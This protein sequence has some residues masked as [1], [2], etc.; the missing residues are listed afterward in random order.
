[1]CDCL[2]PSASELPSICSSLPTPLVIRRYWNESGDAGCLL[3]VGTIEK[4]KMALVF[5]RL[6]SPA[7]GRV[8]EKECQAPFAM[9]CY[10]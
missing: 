6:S 3:S 8:A 5:P 9:P 1:V 2:Q 7:L 10:R 4:K